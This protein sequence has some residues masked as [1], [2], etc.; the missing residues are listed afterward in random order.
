M[1][2]DQVPSNFCKDLGNLLEYWNV[3]K[4]NYRRQDRILTN[5]YEDLSGAVRVYIRIKPLLG[6]EQESPTVYLKTVENKRTKSLTVDCSES[7]NTKF[8]DPLTFG[9]FYG[10]FDEKYTNLDLY[11]GQMG[12]PSSGLKID[13]DNLVDSSDS[14][15]P[16][17]YSVFNQIQDGY[18][19]VLFGYGLSGS[20]KT[21]T[22]LGS[23]GTPGLLHYGLSNL[24]NV[25]KIKIKY[26]FEQYY[27][28]INFN[29]REVTGHIHNL[30]NKVPQMTSFSKD[31]NEE[32]KQVIPGYIDVNS[33]KVED[34]SA[35]TDIVDSYRQKHGRIK[36]TPN[37]PQSSRSHLYYVFEVTFTNG[38]SGYITIVDMAGRESPI[39]IFNTFIDTTKTTLPSV[40]APPPV[41]GEG[42]IANSI[43]E[44]FV[45]TYHH[46]SNG[47]SYLSNTRRRS[48]F[49]LRNVSQ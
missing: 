30:I 9:E 14:V 24:Q 34:L 1:N 33:M 37:N 25:S 45:E 38:K 23:K 35:F 31:E 32:F 44:E 17:L 39:D 8:K 43:K 29:Y 3:N 13:L 48:V 15:S 49:D 46:P 47:L 2:R 18:S 11:T 26:L 36:Q 27:Y 5:I 40:M 16:G 21:L 7:P 19:V 12:Y 41:G 10:I 28:K 42:N 4:S 20:G 6:G 22:L